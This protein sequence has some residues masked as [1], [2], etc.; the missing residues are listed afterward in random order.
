MVPPTAS[1][2]HLVEKLCEM[3]VKGSCLA[4]YGG[5]P[6][7]PVVALCAPTP[8]FGIS[9]LVLIF[10]SWLPTWRHTSMSGSPWPLARA[11]LSTARPSTRSTT[12]G[13]PPL[14]P[15]LRYQLDLGLVVRHLCV[16]SSQPEPLSSG[17][18]RRTTNATA[19]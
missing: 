6:L 7:A 13:I 8:L 10:N 15:Q 16:T 19:V 11:P 14:Q 2:I 3:L 18:A 5:L 17:W 12:A 9:Y 1:R 4:L